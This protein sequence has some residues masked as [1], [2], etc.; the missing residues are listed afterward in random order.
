M[1]AATPFAS[2]LS[3]HMRYWVCLR[4][5]RA[6][7]VDTSRPCLHLHVSQLS[8]TP[9]RPLLL[10]AH[11]QDSLV[12]TRAPPSLSVIYALI[13]VAKR[14][15]IPQSVTP[16]HLN[17]HIPLLFYIL[18]VSPSAP[19]SA[20]TP[21][22]F[23]PLSSSTFSSFCCHG[24][25]IAFEGSLKNHTKFEIKIRIDNWWNWCVSLID[26][27][28]DG[29]RALS[30]PRR[31][32]QRRPELSR[33]QN[34]RHSLPESYKNLHENYKTVRSA[35]GYAVE[36]AARLRRSAHTPP[37]PSTAGLLRMHAV[38]SPP[39]LTRLGC[40]TVSYHAARHN[41]RL[42]HLASPPTSVPSQLSRLTPSQP[43]KLRT[44]FRIE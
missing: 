37:H 11:L 36:S 38:V 27:G 31:L 25:L 18:V 3:R 28:R 33:Q 21:F 26:H 42:P 32:T 22:K 5:S 2:V 35:G 30:D 24:Y 15:T 44:C 40:R 12:K 39:L 9:I 17:L 20:A 16:L 19:H 7:F 10:V 8:L 43:R 4:I 13:L 34:D 29:R 23:S 1:A 6:I 41:V 14:F